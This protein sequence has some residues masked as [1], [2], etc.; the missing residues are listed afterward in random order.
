MRRRPEHRLPR[1]T[2]RVR[3]AVALGAVLAL[4]VSGTFAYWTD[5]VTVSGTTLTSGRLDLQVKNS[6]AP[7]TASLGMTGASSMVPGS[8]SAEVLP[9]KNNGT[10]PLKYTL[11]GGLTGGDAAAYATAG[12]ILLTIQVNGSVSGTG[13]TA[14]CTGGTSI[15]GPTALTAT[16]TAPIISTP[17]GPLAANGVESLCFQLKLADNAPST[18]QTK[19]TNV[20]FTATGSSNVS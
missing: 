8:T 10:V 20:T 2:G 11:T 13:N 6:D 1:R 19:T 5:D 7:A 17:R 12:A 4:G 18:L 9:V 16:T 3:A 14:T 15:Y